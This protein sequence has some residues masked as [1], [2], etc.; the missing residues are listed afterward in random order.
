MLTYNCNHEFLACPAWSNLHKILQPTV[1][2]AYFDF[3]GNRTRHTSLALESEIHW[4]WFMN[5][6]SSSQSSEWVNCSQ[7]SHTPC[8]DCCTKMAFQSTINL[9]VQ[10]IWQKLTIVWNVSLYL[11]SIW[12]ECQPV[13]TRRVWETFWEQIVCVFFG[14]QLGNLHDK[15]LCFPFRRGSFRI[16]ENQSICCR[17]QCIF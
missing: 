13:C 8:S 9:H 1:E 17:E 5:G 12:I 11:S 2:Y 15:Y 16:R 7:P 14:E 10:S 4:E 3:V 6:A